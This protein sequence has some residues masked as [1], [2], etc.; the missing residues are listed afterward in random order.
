[1]ELAEA[2]KTLAVMSRP[3]GE[4]QDRVNQKEALQIAL[5]DE[6]LP[7]A[8]DITAF[9]GFIVPH[10][11]SQPYVFSGRDTRVLTDSEVVAL[12]EAAQ[13]ILAEITESAN[14]E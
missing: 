7:C 4:R 1:M 6:G 8:L 3:S 14:A 10:D 5:W 12:C 11:L 13:R 9:S 2:I